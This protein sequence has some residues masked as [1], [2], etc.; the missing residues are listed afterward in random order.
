MGK[1][2][3]TKAFVIGTFSHI[4]VLIDAVKAA[5]KGRYLVRDVFSPVPIPEVS[6]FL[7]PKK[8]PIRFWTFIGCLLGLIGGFALGIGS[9]MIWNIVVG[10]KPAV[11]HVPFVVMAFEALVLLGALGTFGAILVH[12]RLP[13]AKFPGP[14]YNGDFAVD[15]FGL[16]LEC[17]ESEAK[18]AT[19][20]LEESGALSVV[21]SA[22]D[23]QERQGA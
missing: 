4:D 19:S 12:G 1:S 5:A 13:Y 10:G 6:D 23:T 2:D 9:A 21:L 14:A 16:W 20:F 8:S 11:N 17:E 22:T 7:V 18:E 3:K 15:K